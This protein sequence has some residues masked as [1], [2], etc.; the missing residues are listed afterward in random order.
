MS[1]SQS[2]TKAQAVARRIEMEKSIVRHLIRELKT[3]GFLPDQVWDGG[4]YVNTKNESQVLAAV[5]AVDDATI[6]FDAGKGA[7]GKSHGVLIVLG[8]GCDCISDYHIGDA[9]FEA[10]LDRVSDWT[11]K[12]EAAMETI[13][14]ALSGRLS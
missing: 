1:T 4:E 5:F 2:M 6:H 9:E 10:V 3:A 12:Y 7:N 14:R 11:R 13:S 8:N